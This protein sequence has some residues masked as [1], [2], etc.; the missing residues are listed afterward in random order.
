MKRAR[1]SLVVLPLLAL[2][3]GCGGTPPASGGPATA[4]ITPGGGRIEAFD[5]AGTR[6]RLDFPAGGLRQTTTVTLRPL[7]VGAGKLAAFQVEPA[8][9]VTDVPVAVEVRLPSGAAPSPFATLVLEPGGLPAFVPT[10]VQDDTLSAALSFF[11]IPTDGS[12]LPPSGVTTSQGGGDTVEAVQANCA[13]RLESLQG[14]YDALVAS[15]SFQ[16]AIRVALSAGAL[17]MVCGLEEADAWLEQV[18][19]AACARY[20]D[21]VLLAD[22]FA[23][24]TYDRFAELIQPVL[25]W[26]ATLQKLGVECENAR[27]A[28]EV[29]GDKYPQFITFYGAEVVGSAF[30]ADYE[31]L[32]DEARKV[33]IL[34]GQAQQLGIDA[35]ETMLREQ[36]LF[37]VMDQLRN[38]SF[39]E[40]LDTD[41]HYYLSTVLS[42]PF[43]SQRV[44]IGS[45]SPLAGIGRLDTIANFTDAQV[46]DDIQYCASDLTLEVW[47]DPDVPEELTDARREL[48]PGSAPGQQTTEAS[49]EG[50]VQGYL[51]LRGPIEQLRCGQARNLE[52]HELVVKFGGVE[53]HRASS[54]AGNPEVQ[55]ESSLTAAGRSLTGLNDVDVEVIREGGTCDDLYASG[56][57]TLFT[58]T[59]TADPVP[60]VSSVTASPSSLTAEEPAE[61]T[62]TLAWT[63]AG[64]NLETLHMTYDLAGQVQ[65]ETID[66]ATS[67][68]VSG[69]DGTGASG[70]YT[71]TLNVFCDQ[72]GKSPITITAVLE[73]AYGQRSDE[74]QTTVGVSYGGC[75]SGGAVNGSPAAPGL[76]VGGPR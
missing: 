40:C 59:Y 11:A 50:P 19:P 37:P 53:V 8:G 34:I 67:D 13:E 46:R 75:P 45:V 42:G 4:T 56:D 17:G 70:T 49:T 25:N 33:W 14:S 72:A 32:R 9:L 61:F 28:V 16:A 51:V 55:V 69:F 66:L 23:A 6:Y 47:A 26:E 10:N 63:D 5:A 29:I 7:T 22:V 24:D 27:S 52:S 48:G 58:V 60:S 74:R 65:T 64:E 57:V 1:R 38:R 12:G 68:A 31:R 76:V 15:N 71:Q 41:D 20:E 73:D 62:F 18:A 54:L 44:P 30:T 2:L 36:V 21:L 35:A 43:T 39:E 3:A